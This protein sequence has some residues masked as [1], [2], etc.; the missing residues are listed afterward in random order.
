MLNKP[1]TGAG[2]FQLSSVSHSRWML[3]PGGVLWPTSLDERVIKEVPERIEKVAVGHNLQ[4]QYSVVSHTLH[5]QGA[6]VLSLQHPPRR[7][8]TR[9]VFQFDASQNERRSH[10][11]SV[12]SCARVWATDQTREDLGRSI[13][14]LGHHSP[15][16][17]N[18]CACACACVCLS[19]CLFVCVCACVCVSVLVSVSSVLRARAH[20]HTHTRPANAQLARAYSLNCMHSSGRQGDPAKLSTTS[21]AINIKK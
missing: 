14:H 1:P 8:S 16:R 7:C 2:I 3:H 4:S 17:C 13:G 20:T 12:L 9:S 18:K 19:V 5:N 10:I 6:H 15:Q 11:G 21:P